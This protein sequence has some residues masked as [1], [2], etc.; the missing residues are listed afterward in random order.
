ME[1]VQGFADSPQIV[2][3]SDDIFTL[4][5]NIFPENKTQSFQ[6]IVGVYLDKVYF[7]V[8]LW[9]GKPIGMSELLWVEKDSYWYMFNFGVRK[10][11]RKEGHG[12]HLLSLVRDFTKGKTLKCQVHNDNIDARFFYLKNGAVFTGDYDDTDHF[13]VIL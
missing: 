11:R 2:S 4:F 9:Y 10:T 8:T 5:K 1:V 7:I 13:W 6:E 12:R 3:L